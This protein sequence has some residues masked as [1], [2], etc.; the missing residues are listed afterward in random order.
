MDILCAYRPTLTLPQ[1]PNEPAHLLFFFVWAPFACSIA[2]H[3]P[4]HLR[5]LA[6]LP[7]VLFCSAKK[8][9]LFLNGSAHFHGN[10]TEKTECGFFVKGTDDE[11]EKFLLV[12]FNQTRPVGANLELSEV[13]II[14]SKKKKKRLGVHRRCCIPRLSSPAPLR[15]LSVLKKTSQ[16]SR[17]CRPLPLSPLVL[18]RLPLKHCLSLSAT[19][20]CATPHHSLW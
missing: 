14:V 8:T 1:R 5:P 10:L 3:R 19:P 9:F 12:A 6:P 16:P 18:Q 2:H 20:A 17:W 7:P 15:W 11:N 13:Y 4:L